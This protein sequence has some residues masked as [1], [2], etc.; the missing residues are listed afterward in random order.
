M[1]LSKSDYMLFLRHPAWLWLKK[2]DPSKLM[3]LSDKLDGVVDS[4]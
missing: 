2:N 1:L 3:A 4:P